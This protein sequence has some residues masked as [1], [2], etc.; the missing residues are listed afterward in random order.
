MK[1]IY[2][3]EKLTN[4]Y[5]IVFLAGPTPRSNE[6]KSWRPDFIKA[7][8]DENFDGTVLIPEAADGVWKNNYDEQI[9]WELEMIEKAELVAFWIPRSL[10]DMPAFTTNVEFGYCMGKSKNIIYGRPND[11]IK[12]S[13]LDYLNKRYNEFCYI[14]DNP[15]DNIKDMAKTIVNWF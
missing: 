15:F 9:E 11:A 8:E 14:Q 5:N 3:H 6:V 10:P 13:Y 2:A 4:G 1:I 12:I 7:L